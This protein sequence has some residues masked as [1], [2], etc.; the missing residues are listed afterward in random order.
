M[1]EPITIQDGGY[2]V[3]VRAD[4]RAPSTARL[5]TLEVTLPRYVLAELNT[6]RMLSKSSAS[7]RAIPVAKMIERVRESPFVPFYWGKNQRGMQANEEIPDAEQVLAREDWM[8]ARLMAI[9][10]AERLMSRGVHKQVANRLLEPFLWHTVIISGTEWENFFAL[11]THR[12]AAPEF[13][14]AAVMMRDAIAASTP[15]ELDQG[16]WHTPFI[17]REDVFEIGDPLQ[18]ARVSCARC[19]RVSFLTHDGRRDV[20]EDDRLAGDLQRRGH[21]APFEHAA[22]AETTMVI[23]GNFRGFWQYRKTLPNEAVFQP[24]T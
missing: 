13:Q 2:E 11:R 7:S 4:S 1:S 8:T 17:R 5:I 16:E 10:Q 24:S 19:A 15:R 14:R 6:H 22:R 18:V 9:Q 12:D 20:V 3:I 21:M 23:S